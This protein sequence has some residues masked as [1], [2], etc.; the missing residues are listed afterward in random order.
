MKI[1]VADVQGNRH[2]LEFPGTSVKISELRHRLFQSMGVPV[3]S[4]NTTIC[5]NG[6][7]CHPSMVFDADKMDESIPVVLFD[8]SL[9]PERSFPR[10][11]DWA[12]DFSRPCFSQGFVTELAQCQQE[13]ALRPLLSAHHGRP[14]PRHPG[15]FFFSRPGDGLEALRNYDDYA[16]HFLQMLA[17]PGDDGGALASDGEGAEEEEDHVDVPVAEAADQEIEEDEEE[18][19][20][21]GDAA[22]QPF[23]HIDELL[24]FREG[25]GLGEEM[26]L[27]PHRMERAR[28]PG[29]N[30]QLTP[31]DEAVIDRLMEFRL[32][33][34]IVVQVYELCARNE[35][36]AGNCLMSMT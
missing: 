15:R 27:G 5:Y 36:D 11:V 7:V 26:A 29:L 32:E 3:R 16:D 2:E 17:D 28:I 9:F 35:V 33:R 18:E 23:E 14:A 12:F 13:D 1:T 19:R 34:A 6:S 31:E 10:G 25:R 24:A 4:V 8:N 30:I 20:L 21:V 22:L